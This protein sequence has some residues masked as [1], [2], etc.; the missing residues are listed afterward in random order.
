MVAAPLVDQARR[1]PGDQHVLPIRRAVAVLVAEDAQQGRVQDPDLPVL[2]D[3]APRMLHPGK[4]IHAV[5]PAVAIEVDTADDPASPGRPSQRSLL[6]HGH[7]HRAIRRD[8]HRHRIAHRGRRRKQAYLEPRRRLH[9]LADHLVIDRLQ[10]G[11]PARGTEVELRAIAVLLPREL[12][13]NR[14]RPPLREGPQVG[15]RGSPRRP[16]AHGRLRTLGPRR[17]LSFEDGPRGALERRDI[18][19]QAILAKNGRREILDDLLMGLAHFL[20]GEQPVG[21]AVLAAVRVGEAHVHELIGR[22][23]HQEIRER[24]LLIARNEDEPICLRV[25]VQRVVV[26]EREEAIGVRDQGLHGHES[27]EPVHVEIRRD[28]L[29]ELLIAAPLDQADEL[30]QCLAWWGIGSARGR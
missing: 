11:T 29:A 20:D 7:V 30:D 22:P 6:V 15:G 9:D 16:E 26:R 21:Q 25:Q 2:R 8:R 18:G 19:Q 1:Q 3:H 5:G 23:H 14:A 10:R 12:I 24:E 28:L 4:H 13:G 17:R 27:Q